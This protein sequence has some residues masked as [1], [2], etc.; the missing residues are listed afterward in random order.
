MADENVYPE[1]EGSGATRNF[2]CNAMNGAA[3]CQ[4]ESGDRTKMESHMHVHWG[5]QPRKCPEPSCPLTFADASNCDRHAKSHLPE[6]DRV[7]KNC[8]EV[9]CAFR[10]RTN[11]NLVAHMRVHS[12]ERPFKCPYGTCTY[13]AMQQG[14]ITR[15]VRTHT[16]E[17]PFKCGKC[18][19]YFQESGG[20]NH[21]QKKCAGSQ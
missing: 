10:C 21:H 1:Q 11:Q 20:R 9:G 14:Q 15:H 3:P 19:S 13:S 18:E 5:T 6:E 2:K 4:F 17:R 8:K 16:G 12:G 7:W